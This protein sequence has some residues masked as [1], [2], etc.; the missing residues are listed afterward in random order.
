M[1]ERCGNVDWGVEYVWVID[2]ARGGNLVARN[3]RSASGTYRYK[4]VFGIG[5]DGFFTGRRFNPMDNLV[6]LPG[7]SGSAR[8]FLTGPARVEVGAES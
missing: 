1:F 4:N 8:R 6:A 5:A 7:M 3:N 2:P